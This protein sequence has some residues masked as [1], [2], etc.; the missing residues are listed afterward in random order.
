[1][2][3]SFSLAAEDISEK[4]QP[5]GNSPEKV[6]CDLLVVGGGSAGV[7]AAIQAG[8]LGMKTILME[9]GCTI[10]GNMTVGGVN[11]PECF[12]RNDVQSIAGIGWEWCV[13]TAEMD[14]GILADSK[15]HYRINPAVA[16]C[17]GEE[18]LMEAGVEIRYWESPMEVEKLPPEEKPWNWRVTSAALG[19]KRIIRCKQM[20]DC[21]GNGTLCALAGASRMREEETMAGSFNYS[22]R[23]SCSLTKAEAQ[24]YYEAALKDGRLQEGDALFGTESLLYHQRSN[25]VYHADNSTARLR[26]ETN[27]RGRQSAMRVLRFLRS[28]PG[29]EDAVITSMFP[30]VGV[31]E[32]WRVEGVHVMQVEDYLAGKVWEDS[33]CFACYQVDLHKPQWKDFVRIPLKKGIRGTVPLRALIPTEVENLMMAGR[34]ISADRQPLS[35]VRI[36]AT[37]MAT[38]QAAGAAAALAVQQET[39]PAQVD[40]ARLKEILQKHHAIVPEF[41]SPSH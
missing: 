35:A 21:T 22:I 10:G 6:G 24:P 36:Q 8:R 25:Y 16:V 37:C 23:H 30:E 3:T 17:V 1:M 13:K 32:T 20:I 39:T 26:T 31:R 40:I 11:S 34:C 38:G 4:G 29:G 7:P 27:L 41:P 18:L 19:E 33:I 12:I 14:D 5:F 15:P 9:V 28:L 2:I